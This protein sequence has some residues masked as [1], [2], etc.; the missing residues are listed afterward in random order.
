MCT[1]QLSVTTDAVMFV[2]VLRF[3]RLE[4]LGLEGGN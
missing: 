2:F 3:S 4:L 1:M